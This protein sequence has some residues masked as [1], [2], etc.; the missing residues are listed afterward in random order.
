MLFICCLINV[1]AQIGINTNPF[2]YEEKFENLGATVAGWSNNSTIPNWYAARQNGAVEEYFVNNNSEISGLYSY[3]TNSERALGSLAAPASGNIVFGAHFKNNTGAMMTSLHLSFRVEH[4]RSPATTLIG[5]QRTK[6]SYSISNNIDLTANGLLSDQFFT[7]IPEAYLT[8]VDTTGAVVALNGNSFFSTIEVFL[9]I[10][11]PNGSEFF[12]RFEDE[13][14]AIFADVGLAIDD[15]EVTFSTDVVARISAISGST[16]F[17]Y[18]DMGIVEDIPETG[19]YIE[20]QDA[21]SIAWLT[22]LHAFYNDTDLSD[23]DGSAYGYVTVEFTEEV[24]GRQYQILRKQS[25]SPFF[26]GT[27]IKPVVAGNNS[28]HIQAPHAIDDINSGKQAA[29]VFYVTEAKGLMLPGISRCAAD[30]G[31]LACYGTTG[32][33]HPDGKEEPFRASDAAHSVNSIFHIATIVAGTLSPSVVFV[34]LHGFVQG[35]TDPDFIVSCGTLD[36]MIKS[37]PDYAAMFRENLMNMNPTL[38]FRITHVDSYSKLG[39]QTNVQGRFL[40]MY[41]NN[42]CDDGDAPT[43]VTNRFLHIEQFIKYRRSPLYMLEL[44]NALSQT[45]NDNLYERSVSID[46]DLTYQQTFDNFFDINASEYRW[47]NNIQIKGWYAAGTVDGLFTEYHIAHGQMNSGGIYSFGA[48]GSSERAFGSIATSPSGSAGHIAYG[49]LFENNTGQ[50][51]H[52]IKLTYDSEQWRDSDQNGIQTVELSYQIA[53]EI[54]LLHPQ[55]LLENN[56]FLPVPGGA[57]SSANIGSGIGPLV[58]N[59]NAVPIEVTI[60]FELHDGAEL[61]I[62]FFDIDNVGFDKGLAIDNFT[63]SFLTEVPMPVNWSYF[64]VSK[65]NGLPFLEWAAEN[66][67]SCENYAVLKSEDGKIFETIATVPCK[68]NELE[69]HYQFTDRS[70]LWQK[71][72]YYKIAQYD[73]NG[74]TTHSPIKTFTRESA[75]IPLVYFQNHEL[76][77]ETDTEIKLESVNVFDFMGRLLC[78]GSATRN[79]GSYRLPCVIGNSQLLIVQLIFDYAIHVIPMRIGSR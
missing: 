53:D 18:F 79:D 6:V 66:E 32:V 59:E 70:M 68:R 58:G 54:D 36:A 41:E 75:T 21:D 38:D 27:Y 30:L 1:R 15:L 47:G 7:D 13:D 55:A 35:L 19:T 73:E 74:E 10:N 62:R 52:G 34:Q 76:I 61:F 77:I 4:W 37:V 26:W 64:K 44:A 29:M 57:L 45:I 42:I 51:L 2:I 9:P 20:P 40:N 50:T 71:N 60:P 65:R 3:G 5:H 72:V 24:S 25:P 31:I 22:I 48:N 17:A 49:I 23:V 63:A 12:L 69:N 8:S 16:A 78:Q 39:G 11:L 46:L 67:K 33:C 28:L 14:I 56:N 43:T